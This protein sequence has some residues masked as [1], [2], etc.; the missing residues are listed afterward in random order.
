MITCMTLWSSER[1][2]QLG[3][4]ELGEW[5]QVLLGRHWGE[6]QWSCIE[7]DPHPLTS[8]EDRLSPS[9]GKALAGKRGE[10]M[11]R[12]RASASWG[13]LPSGLAVNRT[14]SEALC[15]GHTC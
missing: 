3:Q 5:A 15:A 10:G 2:H 6:N 14:E 12:A 8:R 9:P 11:K 4:L 7:L 1:D 13:E